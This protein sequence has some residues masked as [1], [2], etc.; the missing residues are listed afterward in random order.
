MEDRKSKIENKRYGIIVVGTSQGGFHALKTLLTGL[1]SG[2][3]LPVVLVQHRDENAG[4][5]LGL[6][7]QE[8]S[9]LPVKEVDDKEEILSGRIYLAPSGYH[10][11]IEGDHFALSTEAP[12]WYARPSIDILFESAAE[13][14]GDKV[15]GVVLTGANEDGAQ[16]LA[17]IKKRCGLAVVQDPKTAESPRMPEAAIAA[18]TVD[19]ILQLEEIGPFLKDYVENNFLKFSQPS[20]VKKRRK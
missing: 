11:L 9:V 13:A 16:G 12:V 19:K 20:F 15:I 17:A 4:D 5:T 7:L 6:L 3:P 8:S 14:Y 18:T 2:F 10:L 1:P